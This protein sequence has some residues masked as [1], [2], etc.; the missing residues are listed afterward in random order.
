MTLMPVTRI[1]V[2]VDQSTKSGASAWIGADCSAPIG[3]RS[4]IGS[5]T[6]FM[7][8]PSVFGPT[9][10]RIWEP[11]S[12][13]SW[14]RVRPSVESI[15][16][17]RTVLS[18]RCWATSRTRRFP[19]L[20]V[21]SADRISGSSPSKLTSTTAPITWLMRPLLLVAA[22]AVAI[23]FFLL[24]PRSMP[25]SSWFFLFVIPAEAGISMR[26]HTEV[27]TPAGTTAIA[28]E[29]VKLERLGARDDL[30]ELGGDRRLAL[31]VVLDRQAV[32]HVAGIAGRI[33]HRRHAAAL[34][35]RCILEQS[36]ED[37]DGDVARQKLGV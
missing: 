19:P 16:I 35:R 22:A 26:V 21:S 14:P 29:T 8:R 34:F 17:V 12:R 10:T 6:T 3:P 31:P 15:A 23:L 28:G 30:D 7:M 2:S 18:P 1:E 13:T 20:S 11:V 24:V 25:G 33:V 27:R 32:D 4:S 37:L 9:G 5:P 36:A